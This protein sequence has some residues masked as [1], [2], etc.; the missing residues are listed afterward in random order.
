MSIVVTL[1]KIGLV[2]CV[3]VAGVAEQDMAA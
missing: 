3:P 1:A 2:V